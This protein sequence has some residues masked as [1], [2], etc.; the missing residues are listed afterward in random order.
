MNDAE[1]VA[2]PDCLGASLGERGEKLL[3]VEVVAED[4]CAAYDLESTFATLPIE[5]GANAKVCEKAF[6]GERN[7]DP[8]SPKQIF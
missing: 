4:G 5:P 3:V 2:P 1:R 6:F 7:Q 8:Q